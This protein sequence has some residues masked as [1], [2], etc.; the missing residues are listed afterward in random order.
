[1]SQKVK[2]SM[3]L[4]TPNIKVIASEAGNYI[5]LSTFYVLSVNTPDDTSTRV[6]Q[7]TSAQSLF[8]ET[9]DKV[10]TELQKVTDLTLTVETRIKSL[11]AAVF[12]QRI[13]LIVPYAGNTD[14]PTNTLACNGQAVSRTT[15][16]KLFA[17]IGTAWGIGDGTTTFNLPNLQDTV[18]KGMSA[19]TGFMDD[20]DKNL[21]IA[22][23]KGSEGV[24]V[25]SY[26]KFGVKTGSK[27]F[28]GT[29]NP[30]GERDAYMMPADGVFSRTSQN[31]WGLMKT[32]N[33][34]YDQDNWGYR[35]EMTVDLSNSN[36][37]RD[38]NAYVKFAIYF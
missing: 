9:L 1:M 18:L 31:N 17:K 7:C 19:G 8:Q 30:F 13:G 14:V 37:T 3:N 29:F 4:S 15:Y 23:N 16:A 36:S 34:F 10:D 24:A 33:L 35:F 6:L 32:G 11:E 27:Y 20:P 12:E 28:S 25:G 2:S 21:R 38:N 22:F 5:D 26:Q